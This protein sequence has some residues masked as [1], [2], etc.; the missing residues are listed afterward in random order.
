MRALRDIRVRA[1]RVLEDQGAELS[2]HVLHELPVVHCE[3]VHDVCA[4]AFRGGV[5][6]RDGALEARRFG[7]REG[8]AR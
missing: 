2:A 7:L 8:V 4:Q 5:Y 6:Q 1:A 3:R